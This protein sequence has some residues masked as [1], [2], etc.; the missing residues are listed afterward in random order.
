MMPN[1][2]GFTKALR[3]EMPSD[4]E[5]RGYFGSTTADAGGVP[6]CAHQMQPDVDES[7]LVDEAAREA[8]MVVDQFNMFREAARLSEAMHL[9][10]DDVVLS[11]LHVTV[12]GIEAVERCMQDSQMYRNLDNSWGKWYF[13]S[14]DVD[15]DLVSPVTPLSKVNRPPPFSS[16]ASAIYN[17]LRRSQRPNDKNLEDMSTRLTLER[18]GT[19]RRAYN[20]LD[21]RSHSVRETVVVV[22]GLIRLYAQQRTG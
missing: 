8:Q 9:L 2:V 18:T 16:S 14:N 19:M 1:V 12:E 22:D 17:A 3:K 6:T 10:H 20:V 13:V 21:R 15:A 7:D 11:F 4:K 5:W